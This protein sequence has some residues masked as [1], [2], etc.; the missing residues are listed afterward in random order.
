MLENCSGTLIQAKLHLYVIAKIVVVVVVVVVAAAAAL[1]N[2][3][4]T[5]IV[6]EFPV[7]KFINNP[8]F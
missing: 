1:V 2:V 4:I 8:V 3:V 5:A 6:V 7:L